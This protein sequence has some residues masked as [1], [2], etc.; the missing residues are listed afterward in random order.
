MA[1][2]VLALVTAGLLL[3]V[4]PA[5]TDNPRT[6]VRADL[7][8]LLDDW[9]SAVRTGDS[10]AL[11]TLIDDRS[12]AL[13]ATERAR[14]AA[15]SAVPLADFGYELAPEPELSLPD[16]TVARFGSDE[17]RA[18]RVHLR[19][20]VDGIDDVPTRRPVT[21][22]FVHRPHGWRI[23]D[24]EPVLAGAET[25]TTWR[26]PWDHG[27]LHVAAAQTEGGRSLVIGHPDDAAF[28]DRTARE[29]PSAVEAV[30]ELWD[31]D[32]PR[33]ALVVVTS[34]REEFTHLV[35]SRHDGDE[36][37]AVA[38][39][40]HVDNERGIATGQRIVL[41]PAASE[42]LDG[43][44]LRVVLAHE[45]VHVA[46]R[47]DTVDGSPMW[48]LEGFADHLG[49][50]AAGEDGSGDTVEVQRVAPTL[51]REVRSSG[52]PASLPADADFTGERSVLAYEA[53]WSIA[54]FTADE[55]GHD[56]LVALYRALA[57][58]PVPAGRLDEVL[59]DILG[60]DT[61]GFV[62]RWGR[63]LGNRI[64]DIR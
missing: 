39:S 52:P 6:R 30:D 41:N 62:D 33:R 2:L 60:V 64:R 44:S 63:W 18:H 59:A 31:A 16:E 34:S 38:V 23:A 47:A 50:R 55:F 11:G 48:I 45:M 7:Q 51:T 27:P 43:D 57:T 42:R 53:A 22:L 1:G 10:R 26:G 49:R 40:D 28:V 19:F 4:D 14:I 29:L 3:A 32:W 24:D 36:I 20:A 56:R 25:P 54:A 9:G 12:P 17:V 21:V 58:G 46:T 13:L 37:A 61:A 15:L 5:D 8:V 35:G